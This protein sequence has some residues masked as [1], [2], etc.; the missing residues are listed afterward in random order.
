[1]KF[2]KGDKVK[3]VKKYPP[4]LTLG[5][6]YTIFEVC[7]SN[8]KVMGDLDQEDVFCLDSNFELVEE[9][10]E[11]NT[12]VDTNIPETR[13]SVFEAINSERNYQINKWGDET[14]IIHNP[15]RISA[16]ILWMEHYLQEAR[17]LA[18]TTDETKGTKTQEAIMDILRKVVTLGVVCGEVHGMPKRN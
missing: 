3:C 17:R 12:T 4:F 5:K 10:K 13:Q 2:K 9:P 18:S 8:V 7:D 16:Y 11:N 6:E 14:E 1:M 15:K